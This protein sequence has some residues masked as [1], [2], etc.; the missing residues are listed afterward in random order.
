MDVTQTIETRRKPVCMEL[1]PL[2]FWIAHQMVGSASDAEERP[3][4]GTGRMGGLVPR[5]LP[6]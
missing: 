3:G 1:R 6:S 2:L 5:R 4:P